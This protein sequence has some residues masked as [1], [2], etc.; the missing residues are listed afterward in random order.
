MSKIG[1][2]KEALFNMVDLM[3]LIKDNELSLE[4]VLKIKRI[5]ESDKIE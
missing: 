3:I 5:I 4:I 2:M 1:T